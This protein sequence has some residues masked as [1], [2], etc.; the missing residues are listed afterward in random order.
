MKTA[1]LNVQRLARKTRLWAF[2]GVVCASLC[3]AHAAAAAGQS[4]TNSAAPTSTDEMLLKAIRTVPPNAS[5]SLNFPA[6]K[7]AP[8]TNLHPAAAEQHKLAIGDRLSFK[9]VEDEEGTNTPLFVTDSGDV[10]VPYIGRVPAENKTCKQL[11]AEIK[12][13]LEKDYYYQATVVLAVDLMSKSR[14]RVY[15]VGAVRLPGPVEMPSDESLTLSK[16]ILRAGGLPK[17]LMARRTPTIRQRSRIGHR[18]FSHLAT[19][20]VHQLPSGASRRDLSA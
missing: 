19:H 14:G 13:A 15:L 6:I 12:T 4:P 5:N 20:P 11:A 9:I 2:S 10:E 8:A 16:A 3:L 1:N 18:W 7:P 17:N